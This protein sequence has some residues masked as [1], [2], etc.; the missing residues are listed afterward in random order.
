MDASLHRL[1]VTPAPAAFQRV[2]LA[3]PGGGAPVD[4][5]YYQR[6]VRGRGAGRQPH[7][8]ILQFPAGAA[9][10]QPD[11][12]NRTHVDRHVKPKRILGATTRTLR[13][14]LERCESVHLCRKG[15]CTQPGAVHCKAYSAADS[16]ALVDLGAYGKFGGWRCLILLGRGTVKM[17][18]RL[19]SW[20]TCCCS[21]AASPRR[22]SEQGVLRALD[23]LD[24][25][26]ESEAEVTADPC[27]AVLVGL[28][29]QGKPR[30]FELLR[31]PLVRWRGTWSFLILVVGP[32][33]VS[34]IITA[35]M[36]SCQG[37]TCR[38]RGLL[39]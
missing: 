8:L 15:E 27:E 26:S 28:E 13:E 12:S 20:C 33:L 34:A 35:Y 39:L 36:L 7:D 21:R 32:V 1:P 14:E 31:S 24:P 30:A 17:K 16:E 22:I 9:R 38:Q 29:L 18:C 25:D 19:T 2:A 11:W 3:G 37:R 4:T 10:V 23:P 6:Q 5:E